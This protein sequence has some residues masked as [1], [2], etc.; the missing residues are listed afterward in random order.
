MTS[1][2]WSSY[3]RLPSA[4]IIGPY[5]YTPSEWEKIHSKSGW[6]Q[7]HSGLHASVLQVSS[8]TKSGKSRMWRTA[9]LVAHALQWVQPEEACWRNG[10]AQ[11][12]RDFSAEAWNWL[13]EVTVRCDYRAITLATMDASGGGE[14]TAVCV[15]LGDNESLKEGWWGKEGLGRLAKV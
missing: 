4:G 13:W 3:F 11:S 1:N 10:A 14:V 2:L 5:L 7:T 9:G 6:P 12:G 15:L 8:G